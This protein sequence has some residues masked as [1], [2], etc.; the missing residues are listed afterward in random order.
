MSSPVRGGVLP[1]LPTDPG[2][3]VEIQEPCFYSFRMELTGP[4]QEEQGG[5]APFPGQHKASVEQGCP[6]RLGWELE[7]APLLLLMAQLQSRTSRKTL[8]AGAICHR[9][10]DA[11]PQTLSKKDAGAFV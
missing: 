7:A 8:S 2:A 3:R 9:S 4:E 10:P 11:Q 6:P 1:Q 5:Q